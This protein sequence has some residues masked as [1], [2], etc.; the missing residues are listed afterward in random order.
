MEKLNKTKNS[1]YIYVYDFKILRRYG[2]LKKFWFWIFL[3]IY[4]LYSRLDDFN[5]KIKIVLYLIYNQS[6]SHIQL[7]CL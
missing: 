6:K 5:I 1:R 7:K 3:C 2:K 4:F